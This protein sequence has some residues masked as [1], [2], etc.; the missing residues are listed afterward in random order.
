VAGWAPV[1]EEAMKL[2]G[3]PIWDVLTRYLKDIKTVKARPLN[4][5]IIKGIKNNPGIS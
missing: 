5:P 2:G 1:S 3:E 4:M